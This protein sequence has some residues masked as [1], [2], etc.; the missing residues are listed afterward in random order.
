MRTAEVRAEVGLR[1]DLKNPPVLFIEYLEYGDMW[2]WLK[3]RWTLEADKAGDEKRVYDPLSNKVL[4]MIF[5]CCTY[6]YCIKLLQ[7]FLLCRI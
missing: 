6:K 2:D 5:D 7:V 4:W 1:T 3:K